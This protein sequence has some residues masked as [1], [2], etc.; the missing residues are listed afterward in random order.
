MQRRTHTGM[1]VR[2][3]T[4]NALRLLAMTPEF[5][6][7]RI[8]VRT[9]RGEACPRPPRPAGDEPRRQS[10]P[11]MREV[12]ERSEPGGRDDTHP[13]LRG[14]GDPAPTRDLVMHRA[15]KASL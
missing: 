2:I 14:R 6:T 7:N 8:T 5:V 3:A 1:G 4:A 9:C 12:G 13:A 15:S 11:L 10:L